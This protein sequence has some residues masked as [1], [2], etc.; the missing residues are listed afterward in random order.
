MC[1][2]TN[3]ATDVVTDDLNCPWLAEYQLRH[4]AIIERWK[5]C[6]FFED[7]DFLDIN[8]HWLQFEPAPL[9]NHLLLVC[10]FVFILLTGCLCNI[11]VIYIFA[12]SRHLRTPAN[13]IIMNLAI[14]DFF[15][16]IKMPIFLYN[17]LL[18][19]P[20]LGIKGCQIYGFMSGLTGTT[21][22]M[23]LATVAVDRYLVISQ[24]LNVNRKSTRTRAYLTTCFIW[25]YSA[26]FASLPLFGIGK[27]VP[28]GYLTSCSFDYLSNNVKTRSFILAF[29]LA[30]WLFPFCIITTCYTA[31]V[32]Y[33][34]K[35]RIEL[36]HQQ[37][38]ITNCK[39]GWRQCNIEV[40]IAK[41]VVVLVAMWM[42]SWTPYA[43]VA[44]LGI[45]GTQTRLTPG[46]TMFPALFAKFSACVNPIIYTLTHPK[47]KKEILRRWYCFMS[48]GTSNGNDV[49]L[50]GGGV[51]VGRQDPDW[52]QNSN[53][54]KGS[55]SPV[56][57]HHNSKNF[58]AN[59][60]D[61]TGSDI[62]PQE[63]VPLN[64]HSDR[65][66]NSLQTAC[67]NC[68]DKTGNSYMDERLSYNETCFSVIAPE[69]ID[70]YKTKVMSVHNDNLQNPCLGR[71]LD[72]FKDPPIN[73]SGNSI[74]SSDTFEQ[75]KEECSTNIQNNDA[76]LYDK[77]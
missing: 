24:P 5:L 65:G 77:N 28:E 37:A 69:S 36:N 2:Q 6:G 15:M 75:S 56:A 73:V 20:A 45:S 60:N 76:L 27:Y 29:F 49:T 35:A 67:Q 25:L 16:L 1:N 63:L 33:V 44:L 13:I 58:S 68:T 40:V 43:F 39:R 47:I 34:R 42:I 14:S 70:L 51:S 18:Q 31:I 74:S 59:K 66:D 8:C 53:S 26:I 61:P 7:D 72:L 21:S 54:D 64:D 46:M 30:A 55:V 4:S 22:I 71:Y 52:R 62:Q 12:S 23:S 10:I 9:V 50:N 48:S 32:W 57:H 17:S 41:I 19:G 3:C 11:I 38:A